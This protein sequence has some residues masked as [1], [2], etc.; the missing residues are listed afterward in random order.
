[1]DRPYEDREFEN[2]PAA[3]RAGWILWA[4]IALFWFF[5]GYFESLSEFL[6]PL[7]QK[8]PFIQNL[9]GKGAP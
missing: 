2:L 5:Y 7:S 9:L 6:G 4:G 8:F 1:M 3:V